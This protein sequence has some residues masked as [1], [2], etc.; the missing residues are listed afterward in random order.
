[1]G[2]I[3]EYQRQQL[4]SS[5]VGVAGE[6]KSG[7]II[8]QGV[9]ALG[10]GVSAMEQEH[11]KRMK[12][13]DDLAANNALMKWSVQ[14]AEVDQQLQR[15]YADNPKGYSTALMTK[16]QELMSLDAEGIQRP[17]VKQAFLGGATTASK[18]LGVAAIGWEYA[19]LEEN[20]LFDLKD[21]LETAVLAAGRGGG[22]NAV[23]NSAIA[24]SDTIDVAAPLIS[25]KDKNELEREYHQKALLAVVAQD[26][27][28]D[29]YNTGKALLEGKYDNIMVDTSDGRK[30]RVPL[31]N[32]DKQ[33][34]MEDAQ[35]AELK[36]G[37]QKQFTQIFQANDASQKYTEGYFNNEITVGD[38]EKELVRAKFPGSGADKAYID[39]IEALL[40][41]ALDKRTSSAK[42][43]PILVDA[44]QQKFF[45]LS[46]E[47]GAIEK[48]LT[49]KPGSAKAKRESAA[50]VSDLLGLRTEAANLHAKG[51]MR[52]ETWQAMERTFSNVLSIGL[53]A[54]EGM[55]RGLIRYRDPYGSHYA[56]MNKVV[57]NMA[58]LNPN[59]R[60]DAKIRAANYFMENVVAMREA[61]QTGEL[62][63]AQ[64]DAA[65]EN[66]LKDIRRIYAPEYQGLK[67]G[68]MYKGRKITE[69]GEDGIPRVAL[70]NDVSA[71]LQNRN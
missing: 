20:A 51:L 58:N 57:A 41:V 45:D 10:A 35:K 18:Q 64:Y 7:Q 39:N 65:R 19:K 46:G 25:P 16:A 1:M 68:D 59:Q 53:A 22:V 27:G 54:Q 33:K 31:D 6:N 40:A 8:A 55:G 38:I 48:K 17:E 37:V 26:I 67:V 69:I 62:T 36:Q 4:A 3:N 30:V 52:R 12:V 21:G 5:V 28:N 29:P 43:D 50:L 49:A 70:T 15:Q 13:Y 24:V 9:Q 11:K 34:F 2:K 66:A 71:L 42:D 61:T 60:Q 63:P 32:K 23:I 14:M 56:E 47:V 44:I